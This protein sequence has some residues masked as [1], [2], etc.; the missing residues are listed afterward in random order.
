MTD[1]PTPAEAR[2]A[3]LAKL[4][5]LYTT[6]TVWDTALLDQV[7]LHLDSTNRPFGMNDIRTIVPEDACKR[8]GLY[9]HAL[10]G[11]DALRGDAPSYLVKVGDV[12]SVNPKAN[13]KRVNTYLLTAT[14]RKFIEDRQ[15][16]RTEQRKAA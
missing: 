12:P 9:F 13:G 2:V 11:H 1:Y 4:K 6:V 3:T 8:A 7:V 10:V 14:G 5:S 15:A 16:A